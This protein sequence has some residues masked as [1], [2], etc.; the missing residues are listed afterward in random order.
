MRDFTSRDTLYVLGRIWGKSLI[1]Y[2]YPVLAGHR[3]NFVQSKITFFYRLPFRTSIIPS[4]NQ[5][6]LKSLIQNT[7]F[8]LPLESLLCFI[9]L[10]ASPYLYFSSVFA[11]QSWSLSLLPSSFTCVCPLLP[12]SG[13]LL[14]IVYVFLVHALLLF[15]NT[16][17]LLN[18]GYYSVRAQK[19]EAVVGGATSN[20]STWASR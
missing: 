6:L 17:F 14:E 8:A 10:G 15:F 2:S 9:L 13:V 18:T 1:L 4:T 7:G 12:A 20:F 16:F 19:F 11:F 5:N 3:A